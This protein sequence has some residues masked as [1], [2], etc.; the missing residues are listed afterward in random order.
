MTDDEEVLFD[1]EDEYE[2]EEPSRNNE[3]GEFVLLKPDDNEEG[4][5]VIG[6]FTGTTDFGYGAVFTV[7]ELGSDTAY[8]FPSNVVLGEDAEDEDGEFGPIEEGDVVKVT[9]NGKVEPEDE[10]KRAYADYTVEIGTPK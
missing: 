6:E 8:G 4:N 3:N 2:F 9:Y 7:D 1:A 5:S 10:T